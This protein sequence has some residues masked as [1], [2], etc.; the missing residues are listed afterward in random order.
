MVEDLNTVTAVIAVVV[1]LLAA[2]AWLP[3]LSRAATER[4]APRVI[5]QAAAHDTIAAIRGL[6]IFTVVMTSVTALRMVYWDVLPEMLDEHWPAFRDAMGGVTVNAFFNTA[7]GAASLAALW[8]NFRMIP[9][10]ERHQW[11]WFSAA[12]YPRRFW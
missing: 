6:A 4:R 9:E 8:G 1:F 12:F 11:N 5:G 3:Y 10:D 2:R 7:K